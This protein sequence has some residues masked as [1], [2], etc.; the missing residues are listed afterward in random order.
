MPLTSD[1]FTGRRLTR[2]RQTCPPR[3]EENRFM[4][5]IESTPE[6]VG[7]AYARMDRTLQVVRKNLGRPLGLAEKVLLAHL[8]DPSTTGM[9][10]GKTYVQLSPHRGLLQ[11]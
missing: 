1:H 9:E 2:A 10:R 3:A 5:T 6:F 8:D 11:D 7:S 4:I